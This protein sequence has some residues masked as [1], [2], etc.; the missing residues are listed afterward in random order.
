MVVIV[1][2]ITFKIKNFDTGK[3]IKNSIK[4]IYGIMEC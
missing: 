3:V 2:I 1:F 4:L